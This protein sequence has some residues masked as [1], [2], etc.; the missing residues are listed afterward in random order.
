MAVSWLLAGLP[1]STALL[2]CV[3]D[4]PLMSAASISL[5]KESQGRG[6]PA[7]RSILPLLC[8]LLG[9]R[10][11][12]SFNSSVCLHPLLLSLHEISSCVTSVP[13]SVPFCHSRHDFFTRWNTRLTEF[14]GRM[15]DFKF[16]SYKNV[17]QHPQHNQTNA[18]PWEGPCL[19]WAEVHISIF[20]MAIFLL[21]INHS[22][23]YNLRK[24]RTFGDNFHLLNRQNYIKISSSSNTDSER[25]SWVFQ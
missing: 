24:G 7:R 23:L 20:P 22:N 16:F 1:R 9:T 12:Q 11:K 10:E 19:T 25:I 4:L 18:I 5:P 8:L 15:E 3:P 2:L 13:L 21:Q 17:L 14:P 6:D